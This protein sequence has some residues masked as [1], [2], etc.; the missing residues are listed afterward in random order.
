MAR[1]TKYNLTEGN[2][3]NKLFLIALPIM[4]TQLFQMMYNLI[5]MFLLGRISY[6]TVAASGTAGMFIWLSV[7]FFIIGSM[8]AEIGVSQS[9]GNN[10]PIGAKQYSQNATFLALTLGIIYASIMIGFARPLIGFFRIQ[11][12]HVV[13]DAI[14]YLSIVA[15]SFPF[16]F[17]TFSCSASFNGSGNSRFSFIV[18]ASGLLINI[19]LSPL[20][21]FYFGWGIK[22]AA[23][24]TVV[25]Q[26]LVCITFL[27][28]IKFHPAR[29]FEKYYYRDIFRP[30]KE[31]IVR[32]VRWAAPV[33][34]ESMCFTVLTML[35]SPLVAS[36][37][38]GALAV[39]RVGSQIESISWLIAGGFAAALTSF[40]GQNYGAQ[41]WSRIHKGVRLSLTMMFIY[42]LLISV[43]LFIL[44]QPLF[45]L[46]VDDPAIIPLGVSFLRIFAL[47]Q[48]FVCIEMTAAG[49]FRGTGN[50][51]PP[52]I[53]SIFFNVTRVFIAYAMVAF[54]PLGLDGIW[55]A[56]A[57]CNLLRG[58][59][60]L[61]W[62]F[63]V[64]KKQQKEDCHKMSLIA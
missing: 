27:L 12:A 60:L 41:K 54:T 2:I 7:A 44:A 8:G 40:V 35:I 23:A 43:L 1:S 19:I 34:I 6:D 31:R 13:E 53:V 30:V 28:S 38:S 26:I 18:K 17:I 15:L 47:V 20:F 46:F 64:A 51:K 57:A 52:S 14:A 55:W 56:M 29:P 9:L 59:T 3:L 24:A 10:D 16:T 37:G 49:A 32:I 50:T 5:D 39:V 33:S 58:A 4:G 61:I 36:F 11:E 22:G 21:I 62:Y 45:S 48:M 63:V 42:G 25:A